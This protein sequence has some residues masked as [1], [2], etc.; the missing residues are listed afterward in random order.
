MFYLE[1]ATFCSIWILILER[2]KLNLV[3]YQIMHGI[4]MRCNSNSIFLCY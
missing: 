2:I 4:N 3:K 1:E